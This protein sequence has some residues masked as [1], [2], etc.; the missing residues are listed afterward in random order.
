MPDARLLW[1]RDASFRQLN[2]NL[3]LFQ[4]PS[5]HLP[6][7]S[8]PSLDYPHCLRYS[9]RPR[10]HGSVWPCSVGLPSVYKAVRYNEHKRESSWPRLSL[11]NGVDC[12]HD[13]PLY[14]LLL[15]PL[16]NRHLFLLLPPYN[17]HLHPSLYSRVLRKSWP[18]SSRPDSVL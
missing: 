18:N 2:H 13:S 11:S 10:D 12:R 3:R 1:Q 17:L 16:Y 5:N 15:P 14:K 4:R 9:P 8:K 6:L 7:K